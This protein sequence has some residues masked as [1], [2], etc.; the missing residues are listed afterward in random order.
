M[1]QFDVYNPQLFAQYD[2]KLPTEFFQQKVD[3]S[4]YYVG[5]NELYFNCT[6]IILEMCQFQSPNDFRISWY[7]SVADFRYDPDVTFFAP[8]LSQ[9]IFDPS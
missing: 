5:D 7:Q 3:K 9:F 6:C 8:S 1:F 4:L 2:F